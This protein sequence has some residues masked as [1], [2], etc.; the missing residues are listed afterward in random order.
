MEAA[1]AARLCDCGLYE[2]TNGD[3]SVHSL[4]TN[5]RSSSVGAS[6]ISDNFG[7]IICK[8][9]GNW[10]LAVSATDGV[11]TLF[12]ADSAPISMP[13][14]GKTRKVF[15]AGQHKYHQLSALLN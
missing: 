7:S 3:P 4:L 13:T 11:S 5:N 6:A 10:G 15:C 14:P 9:F 12:C 2:V 1:I 8:F